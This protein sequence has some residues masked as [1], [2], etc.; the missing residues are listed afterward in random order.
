MY[1]SY[2]M[3]K[4][5]AELRAKHKPQVEPTSQSRNHHGDVQKNEIP[6]TLGVTRSIPYRRNRHVNRKTA[7]ITK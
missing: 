6:N 3:A 2:V 5:N 1:Y 4:P 7:I